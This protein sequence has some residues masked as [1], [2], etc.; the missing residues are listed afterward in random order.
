MKNVI[1]KTKGYILLVMAFFIVLLISG[2]SVRKIDSSNK[3]SNNSYSSDIYKKVDMQVPSGKTP[4]RTVNAKNGGAY[5]VCGE[6]MHNEEIWH[7][8][9]A[10]N[11]TIEYEFAKNAIF[12]DADVIQAYIFEG[13]EKVENTAYIW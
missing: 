9:A 5:V 4:Q 8:D 2:C 12:K 10:D 1:L 7:I 3:E 13:T 6:D 11:W